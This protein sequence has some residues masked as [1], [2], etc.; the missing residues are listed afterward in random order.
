VP[1]RHSLCSLY[2]SVLTSVY[3]R[4]SVLSMD[5]IAHAQA[6]LES[7][8]A[9]LRK[10]TEAALAEGEYD[11]VILLTRMLKELAILR[12]VPSN[13]TSE[14]HPEMIDMPQN[15]AGQLATRGRGD[16]KPKRSVGKYPRFRRDD[17]QLVKIGWS[18]KSRSEYEH[19]A[20]FAVVLTTTQNLAGQ[21]S[22]GRVSRVEDLAPTTPE[23]ES[24]T[25]SYQTYLAIAWLRSEGLVNR[26]GRKGY[27]STA[28]GELAERAERRWAE[29]G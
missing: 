4:R 24:A 7:C 11:A 14:S 19:R 3:F 9:E 25:P 12:A 18:K 16:P 13:E 10:I 20:P 15:D 29:M 5:A 6:A 17:T 21:M 1:R 2:L 26:V 8:D 28:P 27:T 23:G 22:N